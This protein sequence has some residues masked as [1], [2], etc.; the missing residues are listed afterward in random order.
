MHT[1]EQLIR[2][3]FLGWQCRLRQLSMRNDDGRPSAGMTPTLHVAGQEVDRISV[4]MHKIESQASTSEFQHIVKRTHDPKERFEAALKYFQSSYYQDPKSFDDRLTALFSIDAELP[5]QINGR[6]DC[7]L[8]FEQFNQ[9]YRISCLAGLLDA[10]DDIYQ[11][12]YWHN[13][14]FNPSLPANVQ[15]L[16]FRPDWTGTMAEPM[17]TK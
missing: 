14:L 13:R 3:A 8:R 1:D 15:I 17:P 12:T 7:S 16:A 10:N 6:D 4:V 5:K 11:S 9:I 2:H